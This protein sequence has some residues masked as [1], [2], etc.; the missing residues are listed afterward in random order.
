MS[1]CLPG[2]S[3]QR[4][5]LSVCDMMFNEEVK[6]RSLSVPGF[7]KGA[8]LPPAYLYQVN[9]QKT[10]KKLKKLKKLKN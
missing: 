2:A 8:K 6:S 5:F 7:R 4:A 9:T 3:T 1:V 10:E